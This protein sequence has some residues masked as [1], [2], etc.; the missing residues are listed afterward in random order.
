MD[1]A[2]FIITVY[3]RID[4]DLRTVLLGKRLRQRG[5]EPVLTDS[6]VLTMEVVGALLGITEDK[7]LYRYFRRHYAHFFPQMRQVHRTTFVRQ[8]ANLW[9]IKAS[10]WQHLIPQIAAD[11]ACGIVDSIPVPVCRFRRAK[12][13]RR[14]RGEA[15][16]GK[17][18]MA[19]QTFYGFKL[20]ARISWPGLLTGLCLAPANVAEVDV[21][22]LVA[23]GTEGLLL[24]DRAYWSP[25]VRADLATVGIDLQA[26]FSQSIADP[27]PLRST[28][29][30]RIR[31]RIEV[32]FSH[33]VEQ[34]HIR[35]VWARDLW[36]FANRLLRLILGHTLLL[37]FT[38]DA[39]L[40]PLQFSALFSDD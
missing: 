31:E 4:D 3:C 1:L 18:P 16:F 6:E 30:S 10:L 25:R 5:P 19:Q 13:C 23:E 22:P 28:L 11:P 38:A 14:F 20:H 2:T 27:W 9:A 39:N 8:A 35:Q 33:L 37:L 24:G 26:P 40:P 21:A 7:A 34:G 17:D 32:V 15:A 29:I 36:H 12:R